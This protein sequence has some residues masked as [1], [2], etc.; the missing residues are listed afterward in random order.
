MFKV[1]N[2]AEARFECTFGRGCSGICCRNGRPPVY[3]DEAGR[4]AANRAKFLP[5]MRPEA[6]KVLERGVDFLSRRRKAGQF[7]MRVVGGWCLFFNEGCVLDAV[8]AAE[9]DRA[10]YKPSVC[11]LFPIEKNHSGNWYVRQKGYGGEIWDLPCLDPAPGTPPARESLRAE[12][13]L[14][15]SLDRAE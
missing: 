4:I 9:G 14:A 10:R 13:A 3:P 1:L 5:L 11:S 8:G 12:L 2:L 7:S 6:R 15:E